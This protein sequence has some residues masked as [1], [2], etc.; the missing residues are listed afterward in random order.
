MRHNLSFQLAAPTHEPFLSC[1]TPIFS[2][3]AETGTS[4]NDSTI[5]SSSTMLQSSDRSHGE[6]YA[7]TWRCRETLAELEKCDKEGTSDKPATDHGPAETRQRFE[8]WCS[9]IGSHLPGRLS[10]D[11]R[12]RD[13]S[14]IRGAVH[15]CLDGVE[16]AV[17]QALRE[18]Q[19]PDFKKVRT[20]AE[21][22]GRTLH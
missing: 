6:I 19:H 17:E 20:Q 10:L 1:Q 4:A 14:R 16:E 8:K 12:L 3:R 11:A 18:A 9:S 21:Y 2:Q 5:L 13:A 22:L 7:Q 15:E